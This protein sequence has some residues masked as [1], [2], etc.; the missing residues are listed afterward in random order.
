[1][2]SRA[3]QSSDH[4]TSPAAIAAAVICG[5]VIISLAAAFFMRSGGRFLTPFGGGETR[6]LTLVNDEDE[7][8]IAS[9]PV[10][11]GDTFGIGFIH[12]VNNSPVTDYYEIREDGIYVVKTVYYGFGAGVQTQLGENETLEYGEDGSM[13][14]TGMDRKMDSLRYIVGTVSDHILTINDGDPVSLRDLCGK[15]ARV[16]FE[17]RKLKEEQHK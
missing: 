2:R 8:V 3:S 1:M 9:Y 15:N 11:V 10:K 14:V 7:T 4:G 16:R 6:S 5:V 13:I 17:S 12:S